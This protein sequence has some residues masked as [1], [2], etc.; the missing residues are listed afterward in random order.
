LQITEVLWLQDVYEKKGD[1]GVGYRKPRTW[2]PNNWLSFGQEKFFI[3]I[4]IVF[5]LVYINRLFMVQMQIIF[6]FA[7]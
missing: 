3:F 5:I 7:G 2:W 1:I 6:Q 4:P